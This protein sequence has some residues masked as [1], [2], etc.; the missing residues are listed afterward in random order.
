MA[1]A[2]VTEDY[3]AVL[4]VIKTADNQAIRTAYRRL[5][6]VTH[7]DKNPSPNSKEEF[8]RVCTRV[9]TSRRISFSPTRVGTCKYYLLPLQRDPSRCVSLYRQLIWDRRPNIFGVRF[10]VSGG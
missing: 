5:A 3:Y 1:P 9:S 10:T 7:P 8:Q 2:I 6:R 4:G